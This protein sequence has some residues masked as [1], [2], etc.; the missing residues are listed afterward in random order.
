VDG[1]V[2]TP[3][4]PLYRLPDGTELTLAE[5]QTLVIETRAEDAQQLDPVPEEK[6]R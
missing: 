5:F 3:S 1:D 2:T 6:R 4:P